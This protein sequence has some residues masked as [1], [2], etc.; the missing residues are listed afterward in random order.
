MEEEHMTSWKIEGDYA[1]TCNC[2][3]L[4]PCIFSNL[5][6]EPTEGD[7]KA[8]VA[9]HI[10]TGEMDGLKL[11]GLNFVVFLHAPG[12]MIGGNMKVGLIVDEK[13]TAQQVDAIKAIASGAAGGPMAALAPLVSDFAGVERRPITFSGK[14]MNYTVKA[15]N[16]LDQEI[17]G[18]PSMQDATVPIY[19]DNVAHPVNS[20]LALGKA[21]RSMFNVFGITWKDETGTRNGHFAPFKWAV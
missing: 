2:K 14:G 13:A 11:D 18:L 12:P 10:N 7:C 5:Q 9:M 16:L 4:C 21:V 20:R 3:T 17:A 15:G 1:E 6:A 8:A 19:I